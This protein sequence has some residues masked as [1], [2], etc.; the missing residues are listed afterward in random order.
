M[1][2][3]SRKA[4]HTGWGE[5]LC[6]HSIDLSPGHSNITKFR[7]WSPV[8]TGNHFDRTEKIPKVAQTTGAVDA[9]DPR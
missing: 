7:P 2:V 6:H 8:A 5:P 1:A 4:R 9:F 3:Q